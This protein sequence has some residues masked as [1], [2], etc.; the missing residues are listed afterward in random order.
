MYC[1]LFGRM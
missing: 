1:D